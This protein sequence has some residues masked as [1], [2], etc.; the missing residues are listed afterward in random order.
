M[1]ISVESESESEDKDAP[2]LS[3][4]EEDLHDQFDEVDVSLPLDNVDNEGNDYDLEQVMTNVTG[5]SSPV[6]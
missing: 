2:D 1:N 6:L 5:S 3:S 4:D